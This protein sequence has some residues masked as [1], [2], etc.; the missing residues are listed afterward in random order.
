MSKNIVI[1]RDEMAD[2][3]QEVGTDG[4]MLTISEPHAKLHHLNLEQRHLEPLVDR[5]IEL[6]SKF[7]FGKHKRFEALQGVM[8]CENPKSSP[9]FH[10]VFKKPEG[11][12]RAKFKDKLVKLESRLCNEK[13]RIDLSDSNLPTVLKEQLSTP[14]YGDFVR[15]TDTHENTGSYLTKEYANYYL[16]DGRKLVMKDS[17]IDLFLDFMM[18]AKGFHSRRPLLR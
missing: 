3:I 1:S 7:V 17:K 14:C 11:I 5:I 2:W 9:H 15:V 8:V 6:A 16:L 18:G 10:I 12:D 13:F 4:A